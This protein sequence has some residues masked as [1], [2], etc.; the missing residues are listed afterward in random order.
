[1]LAVS[2]GVEKAESPAPADFIRLKRVFMLKNSCPPITKC[3]VRK[4]R[5][6]NNVSANVIN[7]AIGGHTAMKAD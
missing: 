2:V 5:R 3:E 7:T 4:N 6:L 1:M